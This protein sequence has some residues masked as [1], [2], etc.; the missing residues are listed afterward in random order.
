[1]ATATTSQKGKRPLRH[2][3]AGDKIDAI[4][5][6]HD[7]ESKASVARDIGVPESTL[8]GWCKNEEKLR[9]MSRQAN[10]QKPLV[11]NK[12]GIV[13]KLTEKMAGDA[14]AAAAA[15]GLLGGRGPPDKRQKLDT[16]LPM[17][18]GSNGS[19][20]KYDDYN[21]ARNSMGPLD[22]GD[23]GLSA[24]NFNGLSHSDFAA[25]KAAASSDFALHLNGKSNGK[26][27]SSG[28]YKGADFSK[29]SDHTKADLSMAAISP[30][31][32]LTHLSGLAQSPLALSFNDIASNLSLLAQ[33]NNSNLGA[34]PGMTS[35]NNSSSNGGNGN[36]NNNNNSNNNL[37]NVRPK[38]M[39]NLSP[40]TGSND[41][42][43]SQG[44]TVKN[45]AK[46]QQ[47]NGSGDFGKNI[48]LDLL[49]K[50]RKAAALNGDGPVDDALWYWI[51]SQQAMLG[52][53]NIYSNIPGAASPQR[54]SPL[55][56]NNNNNSGNNGNK[57]GNSN[58]NNNQSGLVPN[59]TS[60]PPLA[61][62]TPH[63]SSTTPSGLSD[64]TKNSS[65]FWQWY[66]TFGTSLLSNVAAANAAN[67][68]GLDIGSATDKTSNNQ[69]DAGKSSL[70]DN[71]LYSQLTK[72][73]SSPSPS[74]AINNN[75]NKPE[76]LSH[77]RDELLMHRIHNCSTPNSSIKIKS[78]MANCSPEINRTAESSS[79]LDVADCKVGIM[80]MKNAYLNETG[81]MSPTTNVR[82][83]LD[84]LLYNV[85]ANNNNNAST[86]NNNNNNNDESIKHEIVDSSVNDDEEAAVAANGPNEAIEHGEQFLKWLE[87]CSDPNITA[88]QVMQFRTLLNSI[89]SSAIRAA[90]NIH[91]YTDNG[92]LTERGEERQRMRKRK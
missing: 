56:R 54:S 23:K 72:N 89:K 78:E 46:L 92:V 77:P 41:L 68:N 80:N 31:S 57:R 6:I 15:S 88:M 12:L 55:S 20:S 66:K 73:S 17:S 29:G 28:G 37:R 71:I 18:F 59:S 74:D 39:A 21:N 38:P 51:K 84:N 13:D 30:L 50:S 64:D 86:N 43:K 7:G 35:L 8:R 25:Y 34:M 1:M 44:L 11:D 19:K 82:E 3:T 61:S 4:Q 14:I 53:N 79:P 45:L 22:F 42:E 81:K 75:Q 85:A 58:N 26:D 67:A 16:S 69:L 62:T 5:R 48:G 9:S 10:N 90:A 47:N 91:N 40:R 24:L 36:N 70:Y 52:L 32:S 87:S 65:W 49:E 33:F 83:I 2:L 63:T 76:D 60:T 27:Y